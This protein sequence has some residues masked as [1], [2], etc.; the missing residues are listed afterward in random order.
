GMVESHE[1]QTQEELFQNHVED[2]APARIVTDTDLPQTLASPSGEVE[3][4]NLSTSARNTRQSDNEV[5]T[6]DEE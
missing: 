3:I 2:P 1:E 6:K 4:I 5:N